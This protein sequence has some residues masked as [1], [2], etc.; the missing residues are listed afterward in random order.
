LP[1][2]CVGEQ[3]T[4]SPTRIRLNVISEIALEGGNPRPIHMFRPGTFTDMSGRET[5]FTDADV[6]GIVERFNAN[7][8]RKPP[9]TERHD[10]GRA[11]GRLQDVWSDAAGNLYGLPK[12]NAEGRTLLT[13]EIYD[14]FSCELDRV[15]DGWSL[16]GGSLTNYPA[17]GGLEPV[18]LAAPPLIAAPVMPDPAATFHAASER[19]RETA[20]AFLEANDALGQAQQRSA[21]SSAA[22]IERQQELISLSAPSASVPARADIPHPQLTQGVLPMSDIP[23]EQ[24]AFADVPPPPM[25][26]TADNAAMQARLDAYM[27]Q[28]ESR[29]A[30]IQSA[31]FA[32]A[33]AE[34]D[35]RVHEMEQRSSIE[36]F[37]RNRTGVSADQAYAIPCTAEELT[38]LLL[39]TPS[40][41]RSRWQTL[42]NRITAAGLMTFDEIGSSGADGE[43]I[44]QWNAIVNAKQAAGMSR[45]DA[46]K[47]TAREHPDLYQAQQ[48]PKGRR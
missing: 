37:A 10:F 2:F 14:G 22:V 40:G 25:L 46:I 32:R 7:R 38:S 36:L 16:I 17:V 13:E 34:F 42:L 26:P 1:L 18:T 6:L 27:A 24:A 12:W 5:S 48:L 47:Q 8:R 44:D 30:A 33:Q 43:A 39:E 21:A 29:N 31:A 11:I 23:L 9:I 41:V 20:A 45:V 19:A 28:I 3:M 4:D 35:R 15:D